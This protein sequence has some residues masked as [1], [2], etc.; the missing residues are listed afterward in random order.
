MMLNAI[1]QHSLI[2]PLRAH[3]D[4]LTRH[5]LPSLQ[6]RGVRL[7][8]GKQAQ[9]ASVSELRTPMIRDGE[10]L[11]FLC[12]HRHQAGSALRSQHCAMVSVKTCQTLRLSCWWQHRNFKADLPSGREEIDHGFTGH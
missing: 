1:L 5:T 10:L 11:Q 4:V 3:T 7:G 6:R 9:N 2:Y 12:S 8:L